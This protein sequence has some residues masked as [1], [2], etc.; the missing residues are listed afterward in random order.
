MSGIVR[1]PFWS[2]LKAMLL[3]TTPDVEMLPAASGPHVIDPLA[4]KPFLLVILEHVTKPD[5]SNSL[6]VTLLLTS[7]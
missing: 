6:R 7:N 4:P 5:D 3:H 2:L 1:N